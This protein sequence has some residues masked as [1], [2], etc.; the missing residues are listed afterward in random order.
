MQARH[1]N[2]AF[3]TPAHL[4]DPFSITV[5]AVLFMDAPSIVLA[6]PACSLT[7]LGD[8]GRSCCSICTM[9]MDVEQRV[10]LSSEEE[11]GQ[12]GMGRRF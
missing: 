12:E 5:G 9:H 4:L 2:D 1:S 8:T 11:V 7:C 10:T 6:R 3:V